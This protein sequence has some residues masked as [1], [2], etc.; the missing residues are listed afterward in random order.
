MPADLLRCEVHVI[1]EADRTGENAI[2]CRAIVLPCVDCGEFGGCEEQA[3]ACP[4]YDK[5]VCDYCA[6]E[7]RCVGG[8][9]PKECVRLQPSL[10]ADV[11]QE[12]AGRFTDA[13]ASQFAGGL[14]VAVKHMADYLGNKGL[15]AIRG[16]ELCG[17][18]RALNNQR[19]DAQEP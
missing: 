2:E 13:V 7:H 1:P 8:Q 14:R 18:L 15:T 10:L 5:P 11:V 12:P 9:L 6:D 4:R 3:V 16:V 17:A 19:R